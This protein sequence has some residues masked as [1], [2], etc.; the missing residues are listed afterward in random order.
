MEFTTRSMATKVTG[1]GYLGNTNSSSKIIKG[2]K[3]NVDTYVIYLAPSTLSGYNVC[4]KANT[5]C[6]ALCLNESGH[7]KMAAVGEVSIIDNSRIGKTKLLF[8]KRKFFSQWVVAEI[9]AKKAQAESRGRELAVRI[10]GT[11]DISPEII[12]VGGKN[13]LELF[14]EIM[15]YDYTKVFKRHVL[16]MKYPNYD[17]TFSFNG[18]NWL[19]CEAALSVGMRVAVVFEKVPKT[20][21]GIRV[22]DGDET[23][24]RYMDDTDVIVGL[25]FKKIRT[26]IDF[27]EYNFVVSADNMH[28]GY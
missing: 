18:Y 11:S 24:L 10:N 28:C 8:E 14:P 17:L 9:K 12:K 26:R 23:D 1:F 2:V 16:L 21:R 5:E 6:K 27:K 20:F 13:L 3:K 4:P 15:F 22:M 25:K 7:N 19:E